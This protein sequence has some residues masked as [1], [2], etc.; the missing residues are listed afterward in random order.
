ML[1]ERESTD[2][3]FKMSDCFRTQVDSFYPREILNFE[4]KCVEIY[5]KGKTFKSLHFEISNSKFFKKKIKHNRL[6]AKC[7]K[8]SS[9]SVKETCYLEEIKNC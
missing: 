4:R 6:T 3:H 7:I 9:I 5:H 8:G 2:L 1:F